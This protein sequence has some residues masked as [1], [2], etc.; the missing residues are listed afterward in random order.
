MAVN[1]SQINDGGGDYGAM[2]ARWA[3][4][5]TLTMNTNRNR[6]SQPLTLTWPFSTEALRDVFFFSLFFFKFWSPSPSLPSPLLLRTKQQEQ[7]CAC[8][9]VMVRQGGVHSPEMATDRAV[10]LRVE[11]G[12][13]WVGGGVR[14]RGLERGQREGKS[15]CSLGVVSRSLSTPSCTSL[16][17]RSLL[18]AC[19]QGDWMKMSCVS[20]QPSPLLPFPPPP[21]D[22]V[23]LLLSPRP[24]C[25]SVIRRSPRSKDGPGEG[26]R[27]SPACPCHDGYGRAGGGGGDGG[28][29][30][31]G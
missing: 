12:R 31:S 26:W 1:C 13:G 6:V 3:M 29:G 5:T 10:G 21:Q 8:V 25:S 28:S 23:L 16:V 17:L 14:L 22:S 9:C 7:T 19:C 4:T 2:A 15:Q 11:G 20:P 30:C 18:V 24:M 27:V